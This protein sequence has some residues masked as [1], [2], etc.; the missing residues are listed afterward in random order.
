LQATGGTGSI[1]IDNGGT[2]TGES[3][4]YYGSLSNQTCAGNG[5]VGNGTGS[6]A[7]QASQSG[8]Q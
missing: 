2:A 1:V 7:V 6:C 3:Q 8:L 4:V 5:T